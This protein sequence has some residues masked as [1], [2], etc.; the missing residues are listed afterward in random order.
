MPQLEALKTSL[1][2][3]LEKKQPDDGEDEASPR[4]TLWGR[5][6]AMRAAYK[7]VRPESLD[8]GNSYG[9]ITPES[10]SETLRS[11]S[12]GKR[13]VFYALGSGTGLTVL[14][15]RIEFGVKV[16]YGLE[17]NPSRHLLACAALSLFKPVVTVNGPVTKD[18]FK[19]ERSGRTGL[20]V[21]RH[22]SFLIYTFEDA[23]VV[24]ISSLVSDVLNPLVVRL[25]MLKEGAHVF[26]LTKLDTH[27]HYHL[28]LVGST[29]RKMTRGPPT[30]VYHYTKVGAPWRP[31]SHLVE[32]SRC[33]DGSCADACVSGRL[34]GLAGGA[35]A[36]G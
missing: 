28:R 19:S 30:D 33:R 6:D 3:E 16:A 26:M 7:R 8:D 12:V 1:K 13:D 20:V 14:Q 5:L 29:K 24:F 27:R 21:L 9:E 34:R 35:T 15:A 22:G 4:Q 25:K 31:F 10:L 36:A 18:G 17:L 2:A 11:V 32:R 23:T